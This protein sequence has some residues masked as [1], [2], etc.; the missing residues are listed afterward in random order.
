MIKTSIMKLLSQINIHREQNDAA[1]QLLQGDLTAIPREHAAD[2]LVVSAYPNSYEPV[3]KTLMAAL[4]N[5]GIVVGEMA[6]NKEIDLRKQL[7]CWLSKPVNIEQQEQFNFKQILCFEPGAMVHEDKTVV[8]NIFRC[9][10]AFAFEMG[11][12]VIAMPVV[13]SGNQK[14]SLDKI[15]PAIVEAAIF[16]LENGLP[17]KT[18]KLVLYSDDQVGEGLPQFEKIK[19]DYESK[20][21]D[22]KIVVKSPGLQKSPG[23]KSF[24]RSTL[25]KNPG[26]LSYKFKSSPEDE[27]PDEF[28]YEETEY[29]ET[30]KVSPIS[31][32]KEDNY[33]FFISYAH[34]HSDLINKFVEQLKEKDSKLRIFY[35]K[36][37]IP[38][39]GLWIKQIS[40]TIGKS[41]KVLVFLS[42][43][44]DNS[45]VCWDEFQ[46]AK[47]MEYNRKTS[48]IQT[49][50]LYKHELPLIMGIYSYLDCR[51]G[52]YDKLLETIPKLIS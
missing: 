25:K 11:N 28:S 47:L 24:K 7:G 42:P 21:T 16:W 8:G 26:S 20:T 3:P 48:V 9:I 30:D 18:I 33:D 27:M 49:I 52:N 15:L 40:D 6:K 43:D 50:Y 23:Q 31:I 36:D 34:T 12:N 51:E 5:K 37:S 41:K 39:G 38:P 4:F 29:S 2:I 13:A 32:A 10:N 35:D 1:I 46:C 44:Y 22:K 45:P 19:Q 14:V 17:L